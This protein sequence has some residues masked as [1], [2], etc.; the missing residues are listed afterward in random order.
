MRSIVLFSGGLDSAVCAAL[1]SKKGLPPYLLGFKYGQT[2]PI[3][4]EYARAL[5]RE[6]GCVF[7]CTTLPRIPKRDG[8]VYDGRNLIFIAAA[9]PVAIGEK[10]NRIVIGCNETDSND[11]PDCRKSFIR[12]LNETLDFGGY[13]VQVD[14]PLIDKN[15]AEVVELA[16]ELGL[17]IDKTWSCY[18]PEHKDPCG[19]CKACKVREWA[20]DENHA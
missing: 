1:E 15:K 12:S 7:N 4:L 11:F 5:A 17:D 13:G 8:L 2:N 20:L 18:S 6:M 19:I 3:E 9:I 14:A 10:V 16:I